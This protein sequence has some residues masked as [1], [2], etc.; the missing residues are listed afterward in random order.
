MLGATALKASFVCFSSPAFAFP[1]PPVAVKKIFISPLALCP[2]ERS[3]KRADMDGRCGEPPPVNR[4]GDASPFFFGARI[5]PIRSAWTE[6]T[7]LNSPFT[8]PLAGCCGLGQLAVRFASWFSPRFCASMS[9]AVSYG[10]HQ[11]TH[12]TAPRKTRRAAR[13]RH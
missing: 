12:Q 3:V 13:Q 9:A 1:P 5:V 6:R 7:L 10:R 11:F 8:F 2:E 4:S